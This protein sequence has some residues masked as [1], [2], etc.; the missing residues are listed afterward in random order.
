M[1]TRTAARPTVTV[2]QPIGQFV[3]TVAG[4]PAD[5]A[6]G[7]ASVS[8]EQ[9]LAVLRTIGLNDVEERDA[10]I[11][12]AHSLGE[13]AKAIVDAVTAGLQEARS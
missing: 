4:V 3:A 5:E 8:L 12:A 10:L 7:D 2:A 6:L 9:V 11:W 1:A 13:R